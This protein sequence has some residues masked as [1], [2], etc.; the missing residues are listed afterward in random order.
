MIILE[1]IEGLYPGGA[2]RFV[3]DLSDELAANPTNQVYVGTFRERSNS[4]FYRKELNP[5]VKQVIEKGGWGILSK[6]KQFIYVWKMIQRIK[7][8]VVH[9]HTLAFPYIILPALFLR[10]IKFFYTVHNL[11]EKDTNP[12]FSSYIKKIF[13]KHL[14]KSITI[15]NYCAYSFNQYYGFPCYKVIENGCRQLTTTP[16][17]EQ[18]QKEIAAYKKSPKTKV[19]IN[20]ARLAPQKNHE[21]LVMAF[22]QF[23]AQG[24]DA[25]L[26]IIGNYEYDDVIK[27]KIDTLIIDDRVRLLGV[28]HNITDYLSCSDIF[29]L[30]SF[31]EGLPI[32]LLEAGL[33]GTLPIS[34]P[35]GGVPDVIKNEKYGLLS[36]DSTLK[37]YVELLKKAYS[38]SFKRD[39]IKELYLR[40]FSMK[41]C[42]DNYQSLFENIK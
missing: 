11:A 4:D 27:Q 2:Q 23:I 3:V 12:G 37:S 21:L 38:F 31:W 5:N 10:K 16:K 33:M 36:K 25:I 19:F 15:S 35:V 9:A 41:K 8:D 29:C 18:V 24:F 28:K 32:S 6:F 39:D 30:S 34:T 20:V 17:L 26:L 7:P 14:I 13:L 42:A 40:D 1:L 22:N